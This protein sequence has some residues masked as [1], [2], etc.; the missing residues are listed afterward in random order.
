MGGM[1]M[2]MVLLSFT[3]RKHKLFLR[4]TARDGLALI[5]LQT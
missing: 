5:G 3:D 2:E 1:G 4:S